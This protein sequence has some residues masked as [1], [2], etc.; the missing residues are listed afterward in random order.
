MMLITSF[1]LAL[2][3][4]AA[5]ER[6]TAPASDNF[7]AAKVLYASGAYEEALSRLSTPNAGGSAEAEQYRAL[8]LLALGRTAEAEQSLEELVVRAPFFKMSDAEVSPRLVTMFQSVRK[9]RLPGAAKDLYATAKTNF[10][11]KL[12]ATASSQLKNLLALL[13]DEDLASEASALGDF[14]LVAEGLL[15]IAEMELAASAKAAADAAPPAAATPPPRDAAPP[16]PKIYSDTDKEVTAPVEIVRN[17]PAWNPPP[18]V[19]Q[20]QEFRGVLRIVINELGRVE[21]AAVVKSISSSYDP[22][23]IEATRQ[24]QFQPAM[25]N[26]VAVKY[27][28]LIAVVLKGR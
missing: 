27:Q 4:L 3:A 1:T 17:V 20:F 19:A 5:Q 16:G 18:S 25:R 8:C 15:R 14:K 12:Y 11:Q 22:R 26:G 24:W 10:E 6:V 23:L 21:S 28:K 7:A 2:L 9:R 13:A